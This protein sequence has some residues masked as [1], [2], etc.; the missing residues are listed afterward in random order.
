MFIDFMGTFNHNIDAK[1][2]LAVPAKLRAPLGEE[3]VVFKPL[4][5]QFP[6][7]YLY[8]KDG[9]RAF[10]ERLT[11]KAQGIALNRLQDLVFLN[12]QTV[13]MDGQGRFTLDGDFCEYANLSKEVVVFGAGGRIE[14]WNPEK[15]AEI[16]AN[17]TAIPGFDISAI[18]Y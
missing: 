1:N 12:A 18:E 8:S 4:F 16:K 2:R 5:N 15:F 6:C 9:F 10:V 11:Q 7:I 17:V 13:E 3:F 14:L